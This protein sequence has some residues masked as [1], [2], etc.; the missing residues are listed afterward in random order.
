M[1]QE[2]RIQMT[3]DNTHV[4][5]RNVDDRRAYREAVSNATFSAAC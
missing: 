5:R 3:D 4:A 1:K 2:E